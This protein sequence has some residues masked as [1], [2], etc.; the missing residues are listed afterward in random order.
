LKT[1]RA[2]ST[3]KRERVEN[4]D[5]PQEI[6]APDPEALSDP[7]EALRI[8]LKTLARDLGI[9]LATL[10]QALKMFLLE[11]GQTAD[12][13][14]ALQPSELRQ[15]LNGVLEKMGHSEDAARIQHAPDAL[16]QAL[17]KSLEKAGAPQPTEAV[18]GFPSAPKAVEEKAGVSRSAEVVEAS[19]AAPK[20]ADSSKVERVSTVD[21]AELPKPAPAGNG[22]EKLLEEL[23]SASKGAWVVESATVDKTPAVTSSEGRLSPDAA[24]LKFGASAPTIERV[25]GSPVI[26]AEHTAGPSPARRPA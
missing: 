20:N 13:L 8:E 7:S 15:A 23:Q 26:R 11:R 2:A 4:A 14:A 18:D 12:S 24:A 9:E 19:R 1:H 21:T 3:G 10:L 5:D 17:G 22:G 16:L 25:E 6:D